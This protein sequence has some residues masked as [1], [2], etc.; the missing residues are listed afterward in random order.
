MS[1]PQTP[2]GGFAPQT[3]IKAELTLTKED[4][5]RIKYAEQE[6]RLHKKQKG[7][8]KDKKK[9]SEAQRKAEK[10][11]EKILGSGTDETP[12]DFTGLAM[13]LEGLGNE[14]KGGCSRSLI[15]VKEEQEVKLSDGTV[16][17]GQ[18]DGKGPYYIAE[19]RMLAWRPRFKDEEHERPQ[20]IEAYHDTVRRLLSN[21]EQRALD[22]VL[23]QEERVEA[24]NKELL[25]VKE[26]ISELPLMQR[27]AE[28]AIARKV[29][30]A[31]AAGQQMIEALGSVDVPMLEEAKTED[32]GAE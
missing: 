3:D 1:D 10:A 5:V 12:A 14:A 19:R 11:F 7:L 4:L 23:E 32:A 24:L 17:E 15:K 28:A 27:Q 8:N 13:Q 18:E 6:D 2:N 26:A 29:L 22:V 9:E 30:E 25:K 20:Y 31:T 16:L 21:E